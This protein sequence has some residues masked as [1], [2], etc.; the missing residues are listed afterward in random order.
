MYTQKNISGQNITDHKH[1]VIT[2]RKCIFKDISVRKYDIITNKAS[3]ENVSGHKHNIISERLAG[4]N[5]TKPQNRKL[6]LKYHRLELPHSAGTKILPL[7]RN[8]T[9]LKPQTPLLLAARTLL[10]QPLSMYS[11]PHG[12]K[13]NDRIA[14]STHLLAIIP[15]ITTGQ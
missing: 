8:V 5:I 13:V 3:T 7:S 10:R 12:L 15:P 4:H 6:M 1:T 9:W 11:R 2:N 14:L